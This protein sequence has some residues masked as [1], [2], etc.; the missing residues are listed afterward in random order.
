M[1]FQASFS[2]NLNSQ[3]S[4]KRITIQTRLVRK[5]LFSSKFPLIEK[6]QSV[7]KPRFATNG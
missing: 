3:L 6:P 5:N 4:A 7:M 1:Q 2:G